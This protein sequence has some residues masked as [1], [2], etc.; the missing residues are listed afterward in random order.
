MLAT[1]VSPSGARS[2]NRKPRRCCRRRYRGQLADS[3]TAG[4]GCTLFAA[5]VRGRER[6][7]LVAV[8][9]LRRECTACC[10]CRS[11]PPR[12]W[13]I[14]FTGKR[15]H[16]ESAFPLPADGRGL[17][18]GRPWKDRQAKQGQQN[19]G[20]SAATDAKRHFWRAVEALLEASLGG[21]MTVSGRVEMQRV[22]KCR[23]TG[24][25]ALLSSRR[26]RDATDR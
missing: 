3:A 2:P 8:P 20:D 13:R 22:V 24:S 15:L 25:L 14:E 26:K 5:A 9:L 17:L 4:G 12:R 19:Q 10:C 6:R 11:F 23:R 7:L 21:M 16:A 1:V 18:G